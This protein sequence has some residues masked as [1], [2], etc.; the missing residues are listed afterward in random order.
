MPTKIIELDDGIWV[1][2]D[3]AT[4][5]MQPRV[6]GGSKAIATGIA[7]LGDVMLKVVLPM[8]NT[9]R[10]MD[11]DVA[12]AEVEL[13]FKFSAEGN[14]YLAKTTGDTHLTI[15]LTIKPPEGP[16]RRRLRAGS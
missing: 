2:V 3:T 9:W 4:G 7:Q 6:G 15:K 11:R 1:E 10:A 13:G 5:K 16:R 14:L 8:V 12:Q